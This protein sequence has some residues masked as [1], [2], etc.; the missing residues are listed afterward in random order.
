MSPVT[1]IDIARKLGISRQAVGYALGDNPALY[2]KLGTKTRQRVLETAKQLRYRPHHLG[3]ALQKG[4]TNT[5]GMVVPDI[6][7]PHFVGHVRPI[8]Q[9]CFRRRHRLVIMEF[10]SD[11]AREK[12]C[13]EEL[14]EQRC[15][16]IITFISRF[17]PLKDVLEE[18]WTRHIPC[19][20]IG[21]PKDIGKANID[22]VDLLGEKGLSLAIKH[23][24]GLGHREIALLGSFPPGFTES[25]EMSGF[26]KALRENG[27]ACT[28]DR[29]FSHFGGDQLRDG[30]AGVEQLLRTHPAT[31][32][33]IGVNDILITG[34]MRRLKELGL[35][36]PEDVSLV[37]SDNTWIGANWPVSLTSVDMKTIQVAQNAVNLLFDRLNS[38]EWGKPKRILTE[39][40]LVIRESTGPVRRNA[41]IQW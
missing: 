30:Y 27:L 20:V 12:A 10:A 34:A 32:A 16:G 23:L 17:Q 18:F 2:A 7:N 26:E 25:D 3:R 14:L 11:P 21:L 8:E 9:E 39:T 31:T 29:V 19:V 13:L 41:R 37:G 15:D 40:D 5:I 35:R 38:K 28:P 22:G 33:I 4:K 36:V 1:Q 6:N 24:V